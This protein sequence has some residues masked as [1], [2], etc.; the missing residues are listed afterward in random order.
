MISDVQVKGSWIKD[1]IQPTLDIIKVKNKIDDGVNG[2][3]SGF[4]ALDKITSG[5]QNGDFIIISGGLAMGKVAF[6]LSLILNA[7]TKQDKSC[8][9]FSMDISKYNLIQRILLM[10][11]EIESHK[12]KTGNLEDYEWIK[13]VKK[14]SNLAK[15]NIYVDDIPI[16]SILDLRDICFKLKKEN[17]L[18]IILIDNLQ[19]L[20][21]STSFN[22]IKQK[23]SF[24]TSS[25][26]I[27]AKELDIPILVLSNLCGTAFLRNGNKEPLL[28]D[29]FE[30]ELVE[31]YADLVMFIHRPEYYGIAKDSEGNS[32]TGVANIIVAKNRNGVLDTIK[33]RYVGKFTKFLN[34]DDECFL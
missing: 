18:E 29:L 34:F 11:S 21:A 32:T 24:I 20:I 19:L 33:I 30:T 5:W 17:N 16:L 9:I 22:N 25:L 14:A 27:L 7:A 31:N 15:S 3:Q 23:V 6:A 10:E 26:K 12:I 1:I 2:I 13:L 8:A 28:T 4:S